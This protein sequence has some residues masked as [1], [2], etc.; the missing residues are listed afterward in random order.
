MEPPGGKICQINLMALVPPSPAK[1]CEVSN[2]NLGRY[3]NGEQFDPAFVKISPNNRILRDCW[4][5]RRRR[6]AD[7]FF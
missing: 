1:N 3:F 4:S 6:G 5:R 7:Q 2:R